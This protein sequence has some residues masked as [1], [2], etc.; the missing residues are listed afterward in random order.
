MGRGDLTNREWSLLEPH[1]PPP[2]GRGGRWNDHRTVLNGILFRIR[3]G[4]PW[5]DLPERY[6][7]WKTVY[8]RHRRWSADGTWDRLL[9]AV[10]ADADL[11]GRI[12]WGMVGVDSTSCRAHQHAAGARKARP[13]IPKKRT[14]P[15]HHR[16]DEGLGRSRGGLTCK[17]HLAGEG[18]CR[19]MA[20]LIT[21]GQ[22]GDAPQ[23]IEVLDRVR[24]PRPLG[25]RPRTRPDHISG[26]KAYSSRR[27]RRYLRRRRIKHTIPEPKDQRANRRRKGSTGG[28]PAGFDRD[29]YRR[30]NEVERTIN[31]LKNSRA[32]ATHYDKRAYVFHGTVTAAAIRLWLRP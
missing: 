12:D 9:Q 5:R 13:R 1:L 17:I 11:A 28:R 2:G 20:L 25:G 21:P 31:R 18:G 29:R 22:W 24:V 8:E 27:N 30:R 14:T 4:V 15:R 10:Q 6:G 3:T 7:S 19:P 16:P 26:D 23:M 32:V